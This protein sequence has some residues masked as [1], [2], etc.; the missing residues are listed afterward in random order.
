VTGH[1]HHPGLPGL[2]L[3][4]VGLVV[5]ARVLPWNGPA[6]KWLVSL[7]FVLEMAAGIW[8]TCGGHL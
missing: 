7:V 3:T 4:A 8:L 5:T 1:L 2:F 6:G